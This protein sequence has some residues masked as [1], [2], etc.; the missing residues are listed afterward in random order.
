MDRAS[1]APLGTIVKAGAVLDAFAGGR[2][3]W[4]ARELALRLGLPR[5]GV[6]DLLVSLAAIGLLQRT[7]DARYRLGWRVLELAGG[8]GEAALLRQVA[9]EH[10]RAL[11]DGA[12]RQRTWRCGTAAKCSS[13][14]ALSR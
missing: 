12:A 4:G 9:P 6:H 1:R 8:V 10:L 3:S 2:E 13:S 14:P 5:S 7:S 11:A